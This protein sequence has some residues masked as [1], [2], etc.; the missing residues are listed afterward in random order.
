MVNLPWG[1]PTKIS[2]PD[3]TSLVTRVPYSSGLSATPPQ[4]QPLQGLTSIGSFDG[5]AGPSNTPPSDWN[6]G[7]PDGYSASSGSGGGGSSY[8]AYAV[9]QRA[10]AAE[11]ARKAAEEEAKK[12]QLRGSISGLIDQAMGVYDTLYGNVRNAA[13]SQ[14]K[15]LEDRYSKE[16]GRLGDQFNA[17]LPKIG[18]SYAGRGTYDSSYRRGAE[19]TATTQ[20]KGQL[21]DLSTGYQ[22]DKAK[23]GQELMNQEANIGTG[24]SL[25]DLTKGKLGEVT[26]L[27]E[28]MATQNEINRK[29][30]ELRGTAQSTG[31]QEAYQAKFGEL[32]PAADRLATLQTQL[33]NIIN[34]QAPAALKKAVAQQIIGS[35][36]LP[37]DQK[38]QL[39]ASI[40]TQI[41]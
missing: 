16:T 36:G 32:A 38:N 15:A 35:S 7:Q 12:T 30:A 21:E 8:D 24:R 19:D 33:S 14:R 11:A 13:T 9:A 17:E 22:S 23:I 41:G 39:N 29:I 4:S 26:D 20:F 5:P 27:N 31:T 6:N 10:A 28:L 34:G 3:P 37:E 18:Q 25:L 2:T 1:N 40:T